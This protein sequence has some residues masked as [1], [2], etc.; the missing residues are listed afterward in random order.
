MGG[1]ENSTTGQHSTIAG[2]LDNSTT[3]I[4]SAILGGQDNTVVASYGAI[5][6]G[7]DN[8][9]AS[10]HSHSSV[11]A[12]Q[13]V[14]TTRSDTAY[15]PSFFASGSVVSTDIDGIMQLSKKTNFPTSP[16]IGMICFKRY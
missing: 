6:G 7:Q 3:A 4:K 5:L 13:N 2:G 12:G 16:E 8:T 15:A 1:Q 14:T 10:G 11:V 9:V